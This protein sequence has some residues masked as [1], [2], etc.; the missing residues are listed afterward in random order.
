MSDLRFLSLTLE[1]FKTFSGSHEVKLDRDPGL[2]FIQGRNLVE[3][4]LGSNGVGKSTI[5]DAL[6]W[7]LFGKTGRD[8]RP[9]DSIK[10]WVGKGKTK[11]SL[12]FERGEENYI[13]DRTRNP[14]SIVVYAG[15]TDGKEIAQEEIPKLIGMTEEMFRRTIVLGQFGTM[16]L[17]LRPEQQSQM[18]TEAL[19]LDVWLK[20]VDQAKAATT[21][22]EAQI[23]E[24]E[25][26]QA[27]SAALLDSLRDDI[28][29]TIKA[30]DEFDETKQANV[31]KLTK[32]LAAA[33]KAVRGVLTVDKPVAPINDASDKIHNDINTRQRNAAVLARDISSNKEKRNLLQDELDWIDE[34]A[35]KPKK[36]C[37][38]CGQ[39]ISS[40]EAAKQ[41][42]G[43]E[44]KAKTLDELIAKQKGEAAKI[45]GDIDALQKTLQ[46]ADDAFKVRQRAYENEH[47]V[48]IRGIRESGIAGEALK[49]AMSNLKREKA[50][51]NHH[52]ELLINQRARR[53]KVKEQ[54]A[55]AVKALDEQKGLQEQAKYWVDGFR[56]LRL[57]I[58]DETLVELEMSASRH[59]SMLGL[60]DWGIRF[61][62]ERETASG[63]VSAGFTVMLYPP[64]QDEPIRFESYSG[65][66]SQ[67]WQLA[68][69]FALSEVLL[70]RAGV[71]PSMEVLDE[72][73]RGLSAVGVDDLLDHLRD[74]ALE[75]GRAIFFVDHHSLDKGSFDGTMLITKT[76]KGSEL[77]WM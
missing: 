54:Q 71:S 11:V 69:S 29:N 19:S 32:A 50:T 58:I 72:P 15:S 64:G 4:E 8:N 45:A 21:N 27:A 67:R 26:D 49:A 68:T 20:A 65:G 34:Q 22:A 23:R 25:K 66:E 41:T 76:K 6:I 18:F 37:K 44:A 7:V 36:M 38:E 13:I 60:E 77:A 35:K 10:P 28:S 3:P 73:T 51:V 75:L 46:R 56:E 42:D 33:E 2:Y 1:N 14:N 43:I 57:S 63:K 17:D 70:A 31:E 47:E 40:K 55:K 62:T 16:F 9:A 53:D 39:E 12:E 52:R 48:W 24:I 59:A 74:R 61:E 5:F 30:A